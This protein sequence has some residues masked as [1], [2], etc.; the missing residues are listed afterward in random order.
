MKELNSHYFWWIPTAIVYYIAYSWLSKQNNVYGGK[1]FW[2]MFAFGALCPLWLVVSRVSSNLLFDGMLYDNI[3]FL[4]YA[5][6]MLYLGAAEKMTSYQWI[7][8]IFVI[9]G[10][11]IMRT[12]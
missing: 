8:L 3:M 6:T 1:W 2:I 5:L 9:G 7:G 10:S 4:T 11:I 12:G